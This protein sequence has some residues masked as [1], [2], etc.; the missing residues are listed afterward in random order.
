MTVSLPVDASIAMENDK[1]VVNENQQH[2][3]SAW[4]RSIDAVRFQSV[5][6][7]TKNRSLFYDQSKHRL[8]NMSQSQ[9]GADNQEFVGNVESSDFLKFLKKGSQKLV[10]HER[11][12]L[13][14][15]CTRSWIRWL[16]TVRP[17]RLDPTRPDLT[18]PE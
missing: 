6:A 13:T 1:P 16:I 8:Q 15:R 14:P 17:P 9:K 18:K 5:S 4:H 11:K 3:P 10:P 12:S 7:S 2:H